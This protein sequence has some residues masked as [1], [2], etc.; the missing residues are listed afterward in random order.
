L[1]ENS[2][3]NRVY[4]NPANDELNFIVNGKISSITINTLD[5]KVVK[6]ATSSTVDVS[7]LSSGMY[8]YHVNVDGKIATGNFVKQ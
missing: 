7:V 2:V 1:D 6:T 3:V 5:G 4:P 8:I